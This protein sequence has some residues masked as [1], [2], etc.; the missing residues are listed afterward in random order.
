MSGTIQ[1]P[2]LF[3]RMGRVRTGRFAIGAISLI[4]AAGYTWQAF[5]IP[6]GTIAQPGAGLF[7]RLVGFGAIIIAVIVIVEAIVVVRDPEDEKEFEIPRGNELRLVLV[8]FLS[9]ALLAG[10]LPVLGQ[11]IVGTLYAYGMFM[12]LG[13]REPINWFKSAI[14][15]LVL[16]I[17]LP[18]VF[19]TYLQV[20]LPDGLILPAILPGLF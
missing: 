19:I 20:D 10:L 5:N 1:A 12:F 2:G 9:T 3:T 6:F 7:P 18:F 16:G 11:Y 4:V 13:K 17:G 14:Y 15:A 8:F